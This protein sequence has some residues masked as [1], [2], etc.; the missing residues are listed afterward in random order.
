MVKTCLLIFILFLLVIH[1]LEKYNVT[2]SRGENH[3]A[4]SF[5]ELA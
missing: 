3:K 5:H 4:V 2:G 1:E